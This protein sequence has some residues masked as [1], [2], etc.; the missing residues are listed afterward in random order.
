VRENPADW[1]F[2]L[3]DTANADL[4]SRVRNGCRLLAREISP[5]EYDS[6]LRSS[7][8]RTASAFQ[9]GAET[10]ATE[11]EAIE[12]AGRWADA[13]RIDD[14]IPRAF[15][16]DITRGD[17]YNN[18]AGYIQ[19]DSASLVAFEEAARASFVAHLGE[20]SARFFMSSRFGVRSQRAQ[21]AYPLSR[22]AARRANIDRETLREWS[23]GTARGRRRSARR[24][25][26]WP[27]VIRGG[28]LF[29]DGHRVESTEE[30]HAFLN[31]F[32][33]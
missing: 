3:V 24:D 12:Y 7:V 16:P 26:E 6:G 29:I 5:L 1:A 20:E 21:A 23:F 19:H 11:A 15:D 4:S 14:M 28:Y 32:G 30:L 27:A 8:K 13:I 31:A 25:A 17:S 2:A 33:G 10:F 18:G 9:V 22:L